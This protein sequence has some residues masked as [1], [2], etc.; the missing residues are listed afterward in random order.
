MELTSLNPIVAECN[1][2][3]LNNIQN[4]IV[5]SE[6][7][8]K[9][10]ENACEDFEEGDIGAGKGMSCHGLKGGIGSSS[11][12]VEIGHE[13]YI[14]GAMVLSNYGELED[15][16][17]NGRHIGKDLKEEI[18]SKN[19]KAEGSIIIVIGTDIP[20]TSRQIKSYLQI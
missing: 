20:L 17:L 13:E 4:R 7:V 5:K 19:R 3:F 11:R 16:I 1:D 14:V 9:A 15:L 12:V 8:F 18:D 2:S 6:D 10:I